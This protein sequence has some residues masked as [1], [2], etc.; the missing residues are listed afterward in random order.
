MRQHFGVKFIDAELRGHFLRRGLP[1]PREHDD[2]QAFFTK[3]LERLGGGGFHAIGEQE[4]GHDAPIHGHKTG[5]TEASPAGKIASFHRGWLGD[6]PLLQKAHCADH[7]GLAEDSPLDTT[8]GAGLEFGG[9]SE[10]QFALIRGTDDGA[11][12]GMLAGALDAGSQREQRVFRECRA[13]KQ[14]H[15]MPDTAC[16]R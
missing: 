12:Q 16:L 5:V 8:A 11:C 4:N 3:C 6:A 14:L 9:R 13:F 15:T 10:R 1:V 7:H 2:A